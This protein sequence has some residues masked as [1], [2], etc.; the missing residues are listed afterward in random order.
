MNNNDP[1]I[2]SLELA[3]L[4]LEPIL[5][6]L[7]LVGGCAVGLLITDL[8]RP[9]IRYTIDVDLLTEVTPLANYY[10]LCEK[11]KTLAL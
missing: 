3:A 2:Q 7:V 8:A 10:A 9:P 1:N 6:E 5:T 4:H 11:L